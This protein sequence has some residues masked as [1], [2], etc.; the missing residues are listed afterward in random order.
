MEPI[1]KN[2][3]VNEFLLNYSAMFFYSHN[4]NPLLAS[5]SRLLSQHSQC[6]NHSTNS[7]SSVAS[8]CPKI[9]KSL[10]RAIS[11]QF[12]FTKPNTNTAQTVDTHNPDHRGL[13]YG[14]ITN[15]TLNNNALKS[16]LKA[17]RVQKNL[18][19]HFNNQVQIARYEKNSAVISTINSLHVFTNGKKQLNLMSQ[20]NAALKPAQAVQ[21]K[22][23][24]S[25]ILLESAIK[26]NNLESLK[27]IPMETI[28]LSAK[29]NCWLTPLEL[30]VA[31]AN[32]EKSLEVITYLLKHTKQQVFFNINHVK[33]FIAQQKINPEPKNLINAIKSKHVIV[34][35]KQ[36]KQAQHASLF[37]ISRQDLIKILQANPKFLKKVQHKLDAIDST[38]QVS[39]K[40]IASRSI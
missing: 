35:Q 14:S 33:R 5:Q 26:S 37:E 20:S 6:S 15:Y 13:Q 7:D 24:E 17:Q 11:R 34:L 8:V 28:N 19:V 31:T 23:L 3:Y 16:C 2:C 22:G 30:A 36:P 27:T 29:M 18:K 38:Y 25:G 9:A 12:G 4:S 10:I 39:Q 1:E 21:T 32:T 40:S